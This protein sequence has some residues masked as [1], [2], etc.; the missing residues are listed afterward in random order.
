MPRFLCSRDFTRLSL[1]PLLKRLRSPDEMD[2]G[3]DSVLALSALERYQHR[4]KYENLSAAEWMQCL[5]NTDCAVWIY[6]NSKVGDMCPSM[7][8]LTPEIIHGTDDDSAEF[9]SEFWKC[10]LK[11]LS[12]WEFLRFFQGQSQGRNLKIKLKSNV[13]LLSHKPLL[14]RYIEG[15][16]YKNACVHA[17]LTY[18]NWGPPGCYFASPVHVSLLIVLFLFRFM[19]KVV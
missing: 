3:D 15:D 16:D 12:L 8:L 11:C 6:A 5:P 7:G 14:H 13:V 9:R 18:M 10:F 4:L 1:R 19:P 17:M 2:D